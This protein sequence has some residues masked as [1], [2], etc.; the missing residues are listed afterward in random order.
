VTVASRR[1]SDGLDI[2]IFCM[3]CDFGVLTLLTDSFSLS[4]ILRRR[5][6]ARASRK[7]ETRDPRVPYAGKSPLSA[8][9]PS[10]NCSATALKKA[11][12]APAL[13]M[14]GT[15]YALALSV[16]T[17]LAAPAFRARTA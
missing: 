6:R 14:A 5:H 12:A 15:S 4:A 1:S 7:P 2:C 10:A 17:Y 3:T 8:I 16:V 9:A 11:L 13:R